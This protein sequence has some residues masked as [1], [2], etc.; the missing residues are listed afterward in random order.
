[1]ETSSDSK[2][3]V[4]QY[5]PGHFRIDFNFNKQYISQINGEVPN[6]SPLAI[7]VNL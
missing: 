5:D 6:N 1:M 2:K 7:L 3:V 4:I